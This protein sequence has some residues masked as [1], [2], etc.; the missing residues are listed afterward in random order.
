[1][2][3]KIY[4]IP[5][6]TPINPAKVNPEVPKEKVAAAVAAFMEE[7]PI[8]PDGIGAR[9]N[10]WMPSASDVGARPDNWMP[11]AEQVG[12]RPNTWTPSASEVGATPASHAEN[13]NNPHGVT[14][15]QV[16]ARPNTWMPTIAEIGAAPA[17]LET[18]VDSVAI[19]NNAQRRGNFLSDV[20]NVDLN[21]PGSTANRSGYFDTSSVNLPS[22]DVTVGVRDVYFVDNGFVVVEARCNMKDSSNRIWRNTFNKNAGGWIGWESLDK[23]DFLSVN[24]GNMKDGAYINF[25]APNEGITWQYGGENYVL[26]PLAGTGL[27]L[28]ANNGNG[29]YGSL[30][31]HPDG[32][33]TLGNASTGNLNVGNKINLYVDGEGGNLEIRS[34]SEHYWQMDAHDGNFRLYHGDNTNVADHQFSFSKSGE[35]RIDGRQVTTKTLLWH[36]AAPHENTFAAQTLSLDLSNYDFIEIVF[37]VDPNAIWEKSIA[38]FAKNSYGHMQVIGH[39]RLA[40]AYL[41]SAQRSVYATDTGIQFEGAYYKFDNYTSFIE[42]SAYLVPVDI[43][44]IKEATR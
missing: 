11:T 43:Y 31:V 18:R 36:N 19:N 42:N 7:N 26:R 6:S 17:D 5:V 20:L 14:A 29:Y 40:D 39:T 25:M 41:F 8:T 27:E 34:P 35:L 21:N 1:M 23:R 28:L 10:T 44:G 22:G 12:A 2:S 4:G 33:L 30:K 15:A 9:P 32:Y 37:T 13:K 24:G 3:K 16:G 38:K